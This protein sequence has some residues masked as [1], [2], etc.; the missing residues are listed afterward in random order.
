[1]AAAV[2]LEREPGLRAKEIENEGPDR[3]LPPEFQT[4]QLAITKH[5]PKQLFRFSMMA[6]KIARTR[7][8]GVV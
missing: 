4:A 8:G 6:A 5:P 7:D 2:Q 3:L 1:M